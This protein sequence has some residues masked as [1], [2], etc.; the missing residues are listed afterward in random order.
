[1]TRHNTHLYFLAVG[2]VC[3]AADAQENWP[4]FRGPSAAAVSKAPSLP[5][6]WNAT[7]KIVWR[8]EV[9]GRG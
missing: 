8:S 7:E 2:L 9:P 6:R 3:L 1:M 4:Q 5:E